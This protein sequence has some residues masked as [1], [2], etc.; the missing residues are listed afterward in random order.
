MK[1]TKIITATIGLCM[2]AAFLA[3]CNSGTEGSRETVAASLVAGGQ[4]TVAA[5]PS[6]GETVGKTS[7]YTINYNGYKVAPGM[8]P[9][10]VV[11]ILG[12]D[13]DYVATANCG[14]QGAGMSYL[15]FDGGLEL[16]AIEKNGVEVIVAIIVE[17][18]MI[19]C[20]GFYIGDSMDKV[21]QVYGEPNDKNEADGNAFYEYDSDEY[22]LQ[23]EVENDK[24]TRVYF[25]YAE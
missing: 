5:D 10:E 20:S 13:Y 19:D 17:S 21:K 9:E 11:S 23:L 18:N 8:N 12:D 14:G 2:A 6:Q 3:G 7:P 24:I 15:Y 16:Q 1:K 25:Q 4:E 22:K